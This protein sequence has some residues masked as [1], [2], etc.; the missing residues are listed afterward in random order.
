MPVRAQTLSLPRSI[1]DACPGCRVIACGS[2]AVRLGKGFAGTALLGVPRR[3]YLVVDAIDGPG[4]RE[5]VRGIDD[6]DALTWALTE[7]FK[8]ARLITLEATLRTARILPEAPEVSVGV[9]G[10][11]HQCLRDRAKPWGCCVAPACLGEC[12]EKGL[13]SPRVT[14]TWRDVEAGETL[15]LDYSHTPGVSRLSRGGAASANYWCLTDRLARL[16]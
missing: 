13:G 8:R 7:R 2:E 5:M 6:V 3:G 14:L 11:L 15:R 1:A 10:P 12:C 4:F 9:P 16:R